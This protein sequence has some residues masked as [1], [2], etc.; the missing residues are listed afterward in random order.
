MKIA[1]FETEDWEKDILKKKFKSHKLF[2]SKEPLFDKDIKDYEIISPFIYSIIDKKILSKASKLKY[3]ATRSTGF[4]HIDLKEAKKRGVLVSNVPYY[5]DNTVAEHTFALILALSRKLYPSIERTKKGDFSLE[6]LRGFDL[7]GKTIGIVGLGHIG[8]S[9]ARIAKGFGMKIIAF[10]I[11]KDSRLVKEL[12]LKYVSF[13]DLLKKSD[14]ITLHVPYN[15]KTHHIINKDNVKLIKKGAYLINTARGG[16][17]ETEALAQAIDQKIIAGAGLD[18]LEEECFIKEERELLSKEFPKTCDLK[19]VLRN[20]ILINQDNVVITP[21]N[22]F[23]SKEALHRILETTAEN[24]NSF[25]NK[26]P[27]NLV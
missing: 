18:V 24:I 7:E 11:K 26:K 13:N 27:I 4:D 12:G 2:F 14:I 21:H 6:G 25:I 19:T 20:H 9:A 15:K 3:I 8:I 10:D 16:L 5:G 22:A 17:V 23:N 1:F